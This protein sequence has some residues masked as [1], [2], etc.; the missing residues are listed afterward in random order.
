[1]K[2]GEHRK[3]LSKGRW[4]DA[5]LASNDQ[6]LVEIAEWLLELAARAKT[7]SLA[8]LLDELIG[9]EQETAEF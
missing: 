5:M 6:H 9:P 1:L 4:L 8:Q 3:D 7:Q 2:R